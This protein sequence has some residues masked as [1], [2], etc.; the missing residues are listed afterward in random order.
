MG[1][2]QGCSCSAC[3][4][5]V[6]YDIQPSEFDKCYLMYDHQEDAFRLYRADGTWCGYLASDEVTRYHLEG[7]VQ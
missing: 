3:E 4:S 5:W 6:F 2:N 1:K 7:R